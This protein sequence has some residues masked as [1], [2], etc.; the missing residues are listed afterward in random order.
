[1]LKD[2]N[3]RRPD[4]Q[5]ERNLVFLAYAIMFMSLS[6]FALFIYPQY[7]LYSVMCVV[8]WNIL[9]ILVTIRILKVSEHAI[10]FGAMAAE[11]LNDKNKYCRVDNAKG[12]AIITNKLA[13]E[14]FQDQPIMAYLEKNIIR[15]DA[16]K[17]DLQKLSA[18]V[19]KLQAVS[20]NLSIKPHSNSA[21]VAE[22]WLNI[23]IKPIYLNKTDIFESEYSLKKICKETY[24]LWVI[25][26]IT[27]Y[28]NMEQVFANEQTSLHNFLDFLPVGLYT[29]D[30]DGKIEYINNILAEYLHTDKNAAIGKP[31]DL[32]IA[33]QP[34]LLNTPSGNYNGNILFKTVRGTAEVFVKQQNV[35]ENNELKRRGVVIWGIPNDAELKQTLHLVADKF[36][37]LFTTAPIGIIFADKNGQIQQINSYVA[38]LFEC[39]ANLLLRRKLGSILGDEAKIKIKEAQEEYSRNNEKEYHFEASFKSANKVLRNVHIHICPMKSYYAGLSDEITGIIAYIEDTTSKRD[40][41]MQVAQAQKM[42]AFGQMAGGVAH[43]FNNLLTAVIC[44]CEL[45][46]Q[47]H[48][49]GDPS[50]SDLIQ[51]KNN[52]SRAAEIARQLLAISRKQPLNPKLVDITESFMEIRSLLTRM[53]GER[54]NFQIT[55]GDDLGFVRIDTTQFTQV[56]INL[57]LNA[58][59]AMNGK[60]NLTISTR[61]ER[62]NV[63]FHFGS[64][65]IPP[66]DFVVISVSDTGCGIKP[67]HRDRIFEPFFTT[68]HSTIDSGSGLGLAMVYSIVHQM[69]GFIKVESQEGVGTTFEIYLPSYETADE[70][71]LP[72]EQPKEDVVLDKSGKA[73]LTAQP[74]VMIT[75]NDKPILGMNIAS[76]DSQ[77]KLLC[78]PGEIKIIFVEDEDAVRIVGARG[79]RQKGFNVVECIS[80]E[81]ALEHIENGEKF[82]L[83]ITDMVMPGI[84][85]AEL[86]KIMK[87]KQPDT[88]IILASGYSEEIARKEL[89]GSQDFFFLSKP[90]SLGNLSEKVMEV[91]ENGR[92]Q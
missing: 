88:L 82:D 75:G 45:L 80:A 44:Q 69:S 8:I 65:V 87:K 36:E 47:R 29:C 20:V 14:Y 78:S 3:N 68:K 28:K 55:H 74:S 79:L 46:L 85:G 52:V 73:A 77:R 40:L 39:E 76:F 2:I 90:Y 34:E 58:R 1:M 30:S 42:Q 22:E 9:C 53:A 38:H 4:R 83:M 16:N 71:N 23:S 32:F 21:F 35:R 81:N 84:S 57:V 92:K 27:S 25:E 12:E 50:F 64:E 60:G 7:S 41:E 10:G 70:Q 43:D 48:G 5:L 91:I 61:S 62:L 67:E 89:A 59:D 66:G 63:P 33:H 19:N 51:L 49:I 31:L 72:V 13:Q 54:T 24:I 18:A 15:T 11:I 26:N 86:A 17:L 56:M 37:R 6:L